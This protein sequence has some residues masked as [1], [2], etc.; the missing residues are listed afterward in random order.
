[1]QGRSGS[2]WARGVDRQFALVREEI[3]QGDEE[4][5]RYMRV[6]YE[7]VTARIAVLGEQFRKIEARRRQIGDAN[8]A[9]SGTEKS[10]RR[11]VVSASSCSTVHSD[12]PTNL[13]PA[14]R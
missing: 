10:G 2:T 4:T 7:D 11:G 8:T 6:L 13:S 5:R 3:R 9:A 12:T 1:M 14:R